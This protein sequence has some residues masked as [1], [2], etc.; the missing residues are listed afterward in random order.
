MRAISLTICILGRYAVSPPGEQKGGKIELTD[1]IDVGL[2]QSMLDSLSG[3]LHAAIRIFNEKKE[4]VLQ[5]GV[6]TLCREALRRV[7]K[8][9]ACVKCCSIEDF[10]SY[11]QGGFAL[12]P[13][14]DRAINYVFNL[15]INGIVGHV[16]VGPVWITEKGTRGTLARLARMFGIGQAKFAQL[17]SK[18]Q[19]YSL[20]DLRR[21]GEMVLSTL[22]V[23]TD[24]LGNNLDLAKDVT[25]LR[26][27]VER[28]KKRTWQNMVKDELTGAFRY[29]YGLARLKDEVARAE[30]YKQ[31]LS[32][33]VI[34]VG[35]FRSY[36]DRH[37]PSVITALLEG[38]GELLR[39]KSR[40]T[41]L[42]VRLREEEFL[43]VLPFTA[44][45][46][47]L[48]VLERLRREVGTLSLLDQKGAAVEPPPLIEGS[49]TYPRDGANER[50]LLRK[51]L[52][53]VRQ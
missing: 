46:G 37:G 49:A 11:E 24:T 17:S 12:C 9:P 33:V 21:A 20:E 45:E 51:A 10:V 36:V 4:L 39:T 42:P 16:I 53:K 31:P 52:Q 23:I 41:D 8:H 44:E 35:Q 25:Q 18:L 30:R 19:A 2:W 50:E 27:S 26:E 22:R 47:A 40:R 48:V 34:G 32:I 1:L 5:S 14:C 38:I 28:E 6:A 43:L 29:N 13:Y 3:E 15:R 7:A